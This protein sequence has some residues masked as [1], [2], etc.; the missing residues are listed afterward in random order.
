MRDIKR[1]R[2][3]K[4][5]FRNVLKSPNNLDLEFR[6][7]LILNLLINDVPLPV[8]F[9][10]HGL[11]GN[12]VGF[13]ECHLKPDLLL[14]YRKIDDDLLWLEQIGSHSEVFC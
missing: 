11:I 1:S 12:F 9:K 2:Q 3:F 7:N 5:Q 13:R 10:D 14:I 8:N 4:K 6:F